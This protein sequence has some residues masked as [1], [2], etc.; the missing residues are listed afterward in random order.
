MAP[1][2]HTRTRLQPCVQRGAC[3]TGAPPWD[4]D[5]FLERFPERNVPIDGLFSGRREPLGE[6]IAALRA[7]SATSRPHVRNVLLP[8]YLPELCR[9]FRPPS[10]AQPNWLKSRALADYSGG[11]WR[12]WIELFLSAEGTRFPFVHIDPYYTHAWSVQLSGAKHFWL[13]KP[14]PEQFARVAM[15]ELPR[16]HPAA[17]TADTDLSRI[18]ADRAPTRITLEAGDRLFIPAGWWH[19]TESIQESVTL[20]GNFVNQS[21]WREFRILYDARNPPHSARQ[22]LV[23]RAARHL[24]PRYLRFREQRSSS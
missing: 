10:F 23:R 12:T 11:S 19:T 18:F 24:A 6:A 4:F 20:G 22:A 13:W 14:Q 5:F 21:N 3:D 8:D 9:E 2:S 17:I 15:G 1:S 7:S 16:K